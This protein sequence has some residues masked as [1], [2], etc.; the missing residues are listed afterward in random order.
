[1]TDEASYVPI[2]GNPGFMEDAGPDEADFALSNR[3]KSRTFP[4]PEYVLRSVIVALLLILSFVCG[5]VLHPIDV[6]S[7]MKSRPDSIQSELDK[8][9]AYL[10]HC[11]SR[12]CTFYKNTIE[13]F[14]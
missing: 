14:N 9:R 10:P 13:G 5:S 3:I 1:M 6:S 7:E 4:W 2:R 11:K 12:I 8:L